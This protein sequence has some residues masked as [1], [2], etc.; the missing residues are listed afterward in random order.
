M[1][2]QEDRE[3]F[4]KA[5]LEGLYRKYESELASCEPCEP[6]S[7]AFYANMS[8]ILGRRVERET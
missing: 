1:T 4:G 5:L 6:P 7:P 2:Y 3:L 8:K